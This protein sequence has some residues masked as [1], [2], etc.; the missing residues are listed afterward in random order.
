MNTVEQENFA[1]MQSRHHPSLSFSLFLL[2]LLVLAISVYGTV[3]QS[4]RAGNGL[5]GYVPS[6]FKALSG[7]RSDEFNTAIKHSIRADHISAYFN[8]PDTRSLVLAF[9]ESLTGDFKVANA[10]LEESMAKGVS[11]SLA[12]ALAHEESEFDPK[13]FNRNASSIDRGVFQLNSASFPN[14]KLDDFYDVRTNV[15]HGVAHLAF[16]LEQGGNEVAALAVYNA[17]LGRV[18]KGGTPRRTLDYI[19]NIT[20][21]RD[22]LEALFEAQVV[23]RH[24]ISKPVAV[25]DTV[26][27]QVD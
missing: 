27:G 1:L 3:E 8:D 21:Y 25:A 16:C 2:S 6:E 13:A 19:Y 5:D 20:G 10:I 11:P 7:I 15:R 18:S 4:M 9:F 14:L 17:G 12:F 23:A 24:T 26:T 22:R